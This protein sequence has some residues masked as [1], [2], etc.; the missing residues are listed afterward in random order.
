MKILGPLVIWA[1]VCYFLWLL[2]GR[3]D[4]LLPGIVHKL[5]TVF[6]VLVAGFIV[7]MAWSITSTYWKS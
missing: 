2:W 1:V 7:A 3:L 4:V 5:E 6:M